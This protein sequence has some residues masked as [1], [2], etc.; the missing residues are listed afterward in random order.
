MTGRGPSIVFLGF[1]PALADLVSPFVSEALAGLDLEDDLARLTL[2]GDDLPGD[3][4]AWCRLGRLGRTGVGVEIFCSPQVFLRLRSATS[5]V[6]PGTPVWEHRPAP[7]A[8]E[9]FSPADFSESR[10][11]AFLHHHLLVARDLLRGELDPEVVPPAFGE[12]FTS[13]WDVVV[14]G[15]LERAGLPGYALTDRRGAFSRLFSAAGV[16]MPDHWGVFHSLWEG[17]LTTQ[18]EV[19]EAIRFLPR[20]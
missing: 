15:R 17:G 3:D 10:T 2:G 7:P 12:A 20:L 6:F 5:T 14:D 4:A 9:V 16:L 11:R 18:G 13:A 8:D 19:T 1:D